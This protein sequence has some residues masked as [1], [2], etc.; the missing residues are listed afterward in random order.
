MIYC[1][2]EDEAQFWDNQVIVDLAI[3]APPDNKGKNAG[4]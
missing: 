1:R 4:K 2:P 3:A